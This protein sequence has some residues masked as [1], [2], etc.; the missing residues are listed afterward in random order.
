VRQLAADLGVAAGTVMRAYSELES[1]GFVTTR[2]GG[3]TSVAVT[4]RALSAEDRQR[5][6]ASQAA[7]FVA[8]ARLLGVE[9]DEVREAVRRALNPDQSACMR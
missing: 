3:G 4:P 9:D 6:L 8:Q 2:R 7:A 1:G 5:S